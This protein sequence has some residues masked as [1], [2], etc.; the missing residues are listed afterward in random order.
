MSF[1]LVVRMMAPEGTEDEA[2]ATMR[3][4]AEATRQEPDLTA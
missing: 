4:L 1:V 3:E 2:A